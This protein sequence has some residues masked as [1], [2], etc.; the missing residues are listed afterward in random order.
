M[1][2]TRLR[3]LTHNLSCYI[4]HFL[5]RRNG[6]Y[7][8]KGIDT[9]LPQLSYHASSLCRNGAYPIKGIDTK[10][11]VSNIENT[12]GRRNGAYP[13]KGIDTLPCTCKDFPYLC[14]N[15][16]YPIKGIDTV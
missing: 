1:E 4:V 15:G 12:I 16:A 8:I 13:I 6:A 11:L 3:E 10:I 2:R 14:R 7:P 9:T 5:C